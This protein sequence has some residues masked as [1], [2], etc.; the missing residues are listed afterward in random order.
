MILK[1]LLECVSPYQDLQLRDAQSG[2]C[3]TTVTYLNGGSEGGEIE[4]H[5]N[6]TVHGVSAGISKTKEDG[7]PLKEE[8]PYLIVMLDQCW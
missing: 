5:Y 4:M 7:T 1:E 2:E 6:D 8:M 3:F